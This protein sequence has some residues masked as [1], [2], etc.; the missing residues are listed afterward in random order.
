MKEKIIKF[1]TEDSLNLSGILFEPEAK[2]LKVAILLHGNGSRDIFDQ[3][4]FN[5]VI[6]EKLCE[7]GISYLVFNNRGARYIQKFK[8][9]DLKGNK[10]V[11]FG[12]MAFELIKECIF[13]IDASIEF[14]KSQ[15]YP[16]F[17]LIGG[18]TGA[19]KA[20]VYNFY[21]PQ[22]EISK[23]VLSSGGDDSGVSFGILGEEKFNNLLN[24]SKEKIASASSMEVIW[25]L[26]MFYSYRSLFD[27]LNPDGDYNVFPFYEA[28]NKRLG[29]KELF[30]EFKSITKP[31]LVIYGELDEYCMPNAEACVNVLMEQV[32]DKNNFQFELINGADHGLS[33][34]EEEVVGL[35]IK[36]LLDGIIN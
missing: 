17:F 13:D 35:E 30:R 33:G 10:K 18:S 36:F 1:K 27:T 15:N 34:K 12:G 26:G 7:A 3:Y 9:K 2:T 5:K 4:E 25:E 11:V 22:N 14:L 29:S 24:L 8:Y 19:N 6:A 16:E 28:Q 31:T 23:F 20:A 21:K 32:K